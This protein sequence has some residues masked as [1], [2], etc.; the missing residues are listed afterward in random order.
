MRAMGGRVMQKRSQI[1]RRSFISATA[2]GAAAAVRL[3]ALVSASPRPG[4]T[5]ASE[6]RA[7]AAEPV[8]LH[9][10]ESAYGLAPAAAAMAQQALAS[11]PNRYP[12]EEPKALEEAIAKRF[13]VDKEMVAV[14]CGSI[15]VLKMATEAF[16]SPARPAVVAEPTFEAV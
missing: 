1:S 7:R 14:A 11:R 9:R 2:S 13:G 6:D 10:N 3:P 4:A 12:I 15:E 5:V 8:R 16:C